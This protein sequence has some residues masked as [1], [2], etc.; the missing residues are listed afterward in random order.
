[1]ESK[2]RVQE[3]L[4]TSRMPEMQTHGGFKQ[5]GRQENDDIKCTDKTINSNN[6]ADRDN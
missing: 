6:K 4:D 3:D 5:W 2:I 1:M